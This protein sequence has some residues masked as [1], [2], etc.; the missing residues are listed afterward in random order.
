MSLD[1]R[2][3]YNYIVCQNN[4]HSSECIV[5]NRIHAV[6]SEDFRLEIRLYVQVMLSRFG[7]PEAMGV[8]L[9]LLFPSVTASMFFFSS[10]VT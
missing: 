7:G 1:Y 9:M 8:T 6:G 10:E 2:R 5:I 4:D 3:D